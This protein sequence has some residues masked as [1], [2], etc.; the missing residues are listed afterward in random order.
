MQVMEKGR[1][2]AS[3]A[4]I[5]YEQ[6]LKKIDALKNQSNLAR[7]SFM[8]QKGPEYQKAVL[9]LNNLNVTKQK[10]LDS[11]KTANPLLHRVATLMMHPDYNGQAQF[12]T[13]VDFLSNQFLAYANL[14]SDRKYDQIPDV[15]TAFEN[16]FSTLQQAGASGDQIQKFLNDALTKIPVG[17]KTHR[18]ALSG[19]INAAKLVSAKPYP[20][21][22]RQYIDLYKKQDMGEIGRLE[23]ELKKTSTFTPGF[24]AP[25]IVG[26]TPD[27]TNLALSTLRGKI[28]LVDFWASWCGPCRKENPNVKANYEKYKNKGFEVF[29]VSLDRDYGAWVNA[30]KQDGLPWKHVSDLKGW[31][32][33]HAALYSVNSIPQ[34]ILL[35]REGK[36]IVRNIR[37][38]QLGS[39]LKEIFGE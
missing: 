29:G 34:T 10:L 14:Q 39:Q 33:V 30:I 5:G 36:I 1:T 7:A 23:A 2:A 9:T 11:L 18:M 3:P 13:E 16:F 25:D 35:D 21:W 17:T 24:E 20:I 26:M 19:M 4:N 28:V 22:T 8:T 37:G 12:P 15:T 38:E 31:Q 32:S 6:L 27:S